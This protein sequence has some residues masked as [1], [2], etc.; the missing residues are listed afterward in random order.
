MKYFSNEVKIALMAIIGIVVLFFGL[1]FLKGLNPLSS[2]NTF[3]VAFKDIS[4]LSSSSPIYVNGYRMGVVK[5]VEYDYSR[6]DLIVATVGLNKQ[7]AVPKGTRAE[8]NADFL[9]NVKLEL[10]LGDA[11]AGMMA[12]GDTIQ[13]GMREGALDK[14]AQMVPQVQQMLPKLDSI[15][16]SVNALL[17][18]PALA[19]TLHNTEELTARL[20]TASSDLRQMSAVMARQLPSMMSR[21]DG[22]LANAD[23]LTGQLAAIDLQATIHKVDA[24]LANIEQITA[25]LNQ[26][27]GSIGLLLRDRGLYDHLNA[28]MRDVDSLLIDFKAHP[29]RYI[30]VSVFGRKSN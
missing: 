24:L 1:N 12:E 5:G 30:N 17:A 23:S 13:G 28:T 20:A 18:D 3:Y 4:G 19:Q 9:G 25:S 8:I 2:E 27:Q 15:L 11:S 16:G 14:A 6:P 26:G 10:L 22:V 29:R 7:L 21:A